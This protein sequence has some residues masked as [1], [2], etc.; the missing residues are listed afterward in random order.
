VL[1]CF[2]TE[3]SLTKTSIIADVGSGTGFLTELFLQNG[4]TIYGV[5]PKCEMREAAE[6]L[7][8][9]YSQFRSVVG[10]AEETTLPET[11][12]DFI[13]VGQ[14]FHWFEQDTV[15]SLLLMTR[16]STTAF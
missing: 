15:K 1:E 3:C 9:G 14:A 10:T 2:Q 8:E 12:I 7:L 5:E 13:T 11:R 16:T 4:N 6:R